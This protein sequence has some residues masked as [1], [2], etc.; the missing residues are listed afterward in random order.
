[1]RRILVRI[2]SH[3]QVR[4]ALFRLCPAGRM[5]LHLICAH[6]AILQQSAPRAR[7]HVDAVAHY[8]A[9][10]WRC[11]PTSAW[12]MRQEQLDGFVDKFRREVGTGTGEIDWAGLPGTGERSR[13][14]RVIGTE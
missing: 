8:A 12:P 9:M 13:G 4:E 6:Q 1:M 2:Y 7:V 10:D 11:L 5:A 14:T 3:L